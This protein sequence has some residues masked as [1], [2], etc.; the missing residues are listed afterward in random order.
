MVSTAIR[1]TGIGFVLGSSIALGDAAKA[2]DQW[3]ASAEEKPMPMVLEQVVFPS[4]DATKRAIDES[5]KRF[6]ASAAARGDGVDLGEIVPVQKDAPPRMLEV[7]GKKMPYVL[8]AKGR[9]PKNG[10]PLFISMHGGGA[11]GRPVEPHGSKMNDQEWAAQIHFAKTIYPNDCLYFIPR[12][13]DDN[14]GRWWYDYCQEAYD[15][16][17]R[18][19]LMNYEVDPNHVHVMGISEGGYA[20]LR[21]PANQPDRYAAAAAMAA[22]EPL[23]TTPVVNFRNTPIR[24]DIGEHDTMFDRV[25]LA[26]TMFAAIE[27]LHQ[28]DPKGYVNHL[29]VQQGRGHGI[30]YRE[31]PIWALKH[32]RNPRPQRI[33]WKVAELHHTL[34]R[35]NYWLS[36]VGD[37][38]NLPILLEAE[39]DP[40]KQQIEIKTRLS[41]DDENPATGQ[42]LCVYL[43]DQMLDLNRDIRVIVDGKTVH[44]GAVKRQLSVIA[45]S[46]RLRA[47]PSMIFSAKIELTIP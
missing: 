5:W 38:P 41:E 34:H 42:K 14:D 15:Q 30:D 6:V 25:N 37:V 7:S 27:K 22:A 3:F 35:T 32:S 44:Q 19:A 20:A 18:A 24:L 16:V 46:I 10:W 40:A 2:L 31:G 11:A 26:R 12:M 43:D 1:W 47:D 23:D 28:Q 29:E 13:A 36:L 45:E 21:L 9:K 8:L 39:I 17:I 33:V 4:V